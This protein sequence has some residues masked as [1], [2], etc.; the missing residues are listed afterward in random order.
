MARSNTLKVPA[1]VTVDTKRNAWLASGLDLSQ[2]AILLAAEAK[3]L[4]KKAQHGDVTAKLPRER[5]AAKAMPIP[6]VIDGKQYEARVR[7][8]NPDKSY[9]WTIS[10]K[11]TLTV[12][13]IEGMYQ[14][15]F[16]LTLIGSKPVK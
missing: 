9:G 11:Q 7:A 2:V 4:R 1:Q 16:N 14:L 13:G 10:D 8:D 6:V 3:S 12:D 15:S 5:F